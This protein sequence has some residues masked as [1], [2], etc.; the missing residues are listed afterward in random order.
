LIDVLDIRTCDLTHVRLADEKQLERSKVSKVIE[1]L[2]RLISGTTGA[3]AAAAG[4]SAPTHYEQNTHYEQTTPV[5]Q[6]VNEVT[7]EDH[8]EPPAD[9]Q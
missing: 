8:N 5:A 6:I 4:D 9:L 1:T 3:T 7:I 2:Q